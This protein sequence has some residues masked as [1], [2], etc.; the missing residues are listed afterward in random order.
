[1]HSS[2]FYSTYCSSSEMAFGIILTPVPRAVA[3]FFFLINIIY[4]AA[5]VFVAC[6]TFFFFF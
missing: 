5:P 3:F 1:M 4:L 2:S 6:K